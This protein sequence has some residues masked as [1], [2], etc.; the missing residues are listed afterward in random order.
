MSLLKLCISF[1]CL[2]NVVKAS[3]LSV[4]LRPPR[5]SSDDDDLNELVARAKTDLV[6][7]IFVA[8]WLVKLL[9]KTYLR[10][11]EA[12]KRNR[13]PEAQ[14]LSPTTLKGEEHHQSLRQQ[15]QYAV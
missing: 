5:T 11:R 10:F 12:I 7:L 15:I 2:T 14:P 9:A 13:H 3:R 1:R 8:I 4:G 6:I